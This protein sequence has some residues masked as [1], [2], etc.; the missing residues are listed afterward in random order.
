VHRRDGGDGSGVDD[1]QRVVNPLEKFPDALDRLVHS[2]GLG[3]LVQFSQ[4]RPSR[5]SALQIAINDDCIGSLRQI[6]KYLGK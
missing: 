3:T 5:E 1:V 4:V 2:H 6:L